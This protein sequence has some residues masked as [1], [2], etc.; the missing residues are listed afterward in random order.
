MRIPSGEIGDGQNAHSCTYLLDKIKS[1][2]SFLALCKMIRNP[3]IAI[4]GNGQFLIYT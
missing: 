2:Y 4:I 1:N 3:V